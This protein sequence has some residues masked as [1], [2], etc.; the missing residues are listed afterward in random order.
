M[1]GLGLIFLIWGLRHDIM[2]Q[3]K[4][5]LVPRFGTDIYGFIWFRYPSLP[6]L[7]ECEHY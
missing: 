6:L 2:N 7:G 3:L 4:P 5:L 1:H